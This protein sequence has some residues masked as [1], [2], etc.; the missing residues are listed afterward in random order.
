MY[1]GELRELFRHGVVD[2]AR[3]Y[4]WSDLEVDHYMRESQR[5]FVR[6][7][8]GISDRTSNA[9]IV[10]A[11]AGENSADM[12]PSILRVMSAFRTSDGRVVNVVNTTD[13][14]TSVNNMSGT[15][16]D[17]DYGMPIG[18]NL[19]SPQPGEIKH[20]YLGVEKHKAFFGVL[21][22]ADETI[23]LHVYRQQLSFAVDGD[24]E[25]PEIDE[26]HHFHLMKYMK[27][28]AYSKHDAETLNENLSRKFEAEFRDYVTEAKAEWERKKHKTRTVRYG[29][30]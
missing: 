6:L 4:L 27:A 25:I 16:I 9:S 14:D 15:S 3:P 30:I 23:Q 10:N 11:V 20:I 21:P 13:D 17:R 7:M 8:G 12:H 5:M 22:I 24:E 18:V 2:I 26:E 29:G 28:L 1:A 19:R